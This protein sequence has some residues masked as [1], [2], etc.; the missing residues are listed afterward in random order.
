MTF[1]KWPDYEFPHSY[2]QFNKNGIIESVDN[3]ILKEIHHR[4]PASALEKEI[5][6]HTFNY[7]S[8]QN[9]VGVEP[10]LS[11]FISLLNIK[12][13]SLAEPQMWGNEEKFNFNHLD[14]PEIVIQ[15]MPENDQD[16]AKQLRSSFDVLWN[17]FGWPC[18]PSFGENGE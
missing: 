6:R 16:L 8:A 9:E 11:I 15:Y 3:G 10:P 12:G 14:L 1:A 13:F 2:V 7:I 17:A 18:S 5:I 4:I